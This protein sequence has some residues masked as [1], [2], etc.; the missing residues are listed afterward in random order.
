MATTTPSP[1]VQVIRDLYDAFRSGDLR[2]AS[3]LSDAQVRWE[4][5]PGFP[6]G[7]TYVGLEAV[8]KN[9]FGRVLQDFEQWRTVPETFLDAGDDVVTLGY[10]SC[11]AKATGKEMT[12][13]FAHIWSVQES[14]VTRLRQYA[15]TI[16]FARALEPAP[17]A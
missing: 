14:K 10:Y 6:R 1:N 15:D 17:V 11:R 3:A 16:Q 5:A 9:F 12:S 13:G 4:I 8:I 7:G 2:K